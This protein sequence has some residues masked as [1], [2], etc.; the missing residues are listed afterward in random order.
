MAD[1]P[2]TPDPAKVREI[3]NRGGSVAGD[4]ARS[5]SQSVEGSN[6]IRPVNLRLLQSQ[7]EEIDAARQ[8]PRRGK[9]PSRHSWIVEA[10]EEKLKRERRK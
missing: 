2:P 8:K 7:V 6:P 1:T 5:E 9:K 10:I 4:P 3:I